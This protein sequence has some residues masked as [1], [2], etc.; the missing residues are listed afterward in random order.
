MSAVRAPA[1]ATIDMLR[2]YACGI[3]LTRRAAIRKLTSSHPQKEM[4]HG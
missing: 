2:R 3:R 4:V 1:G